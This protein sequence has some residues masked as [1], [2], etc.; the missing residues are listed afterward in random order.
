[1]PVPRPA[2]VSRRRSDD[3]AS[4]P[5]SSERAG[6]TAGAFDTERRAARAVSVEGVPPPVAIGQAFQAPAPAPTDAAVVDIPVPERMVKEAKEKECSETLA[7]LALC[8]K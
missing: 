1:M 3:V 2:P 8:P 7:A 4:K 6:G 5:R